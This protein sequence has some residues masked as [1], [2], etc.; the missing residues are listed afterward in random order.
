MKRTSGKRN[1]TMGCGGGQVVCML[2]FDSDGLTSNAIN[3]EN[4]TVKLQG[5]ERN[6]SFV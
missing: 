4:F 2:T 3:V 1:E 5:N 6:R